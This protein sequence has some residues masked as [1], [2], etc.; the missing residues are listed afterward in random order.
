[1][2]LSNFGSKEVNTQPIRRRDCLVLQSVL[3]LVPIVENALVYAMP[4]R[5][6]HPDNR[7]IDE[8]DTVLESLALVEDL[9]GEQHCIVFHVLCRDIIG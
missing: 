7:P 6:G 2:T 3:A 8:R 4:T 5:T 1:M 9:L